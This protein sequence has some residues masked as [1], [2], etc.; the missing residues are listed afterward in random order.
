MH[1]LQRDSRLKPL[2]PGF[3]VLGSYA[4]CD[5]CG[6]ICHLRNPCACIRAEGAP[7]AEVEPTEPTATVIEMQPRKKR[8]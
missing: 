4:L 7:A 8:G 5:R 2:R 6:R 3:L 1:E